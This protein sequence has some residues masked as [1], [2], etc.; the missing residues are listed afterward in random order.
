MRMR[1][2]IKKSLLAIA[3]SSIIA[4]PA[5][6][7]TNGYSM[8]GASTKE[9]GLAGAGVAYSQDA[10]ASAN[11]PAGMAFIGE[12]FDVG[13]AVFSPSPRSYT[14]TGNVTPAGFINAEDGV[15]VESDSDFFFIPHIGY[16]WQIDDTTTV[17]VAV[18]GNGGM[19]TDYPASATP[20]SPADPTGPGLGTFVDGKTGINLE[21][22]FFNV[23]IS[24]KLNAKHAIGASVLLVGQK[25][26][27][28]G[29]AGF[30][31]LSVDP[32]NVS[33]NHDD[34]A[35]GVGVKFGY[36]GE[37]SDGVRV[38]V[39]YQ[40]KI[41]MNEFDD[42]AG[43]F[44]EGGD[45]DI[46]ATYTIGMSFEVGSSGLIVADIQEIK[47]S[48]VASISNPL[49]PNLGAC[50]GGDVTSCLGGSNGPGFGWEDMT[51]YKIGYQLEAGDSTYRVGY[52]HA[53]QPI[54]ES[55]VFFNILAPAVV[56]DHITAGWTLRVGD[57]QEFNIAGLYVPSNSV[58]GDNPMDGGQTQ[59]EIEMT[60]WEVQA[61]WAW[62]Y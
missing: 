29:L 38:G 23:S 47:Y 12:R 60:Q 19:N 48:G 35:I 46:P 28:D 17:G 25:F 3:V 55:E 45:F 21:Q 59:I 24:N 53:D 8:H 2:T 50:M 13:L 40:S 10:L 18:Y 1:I 54:P 22:A 31:P 27:A 20:P 33:G 34:T 44:A 37:V 57:N 4:S 41:K 30:A 43:L 32:A 61:G 36:Q 49:M 14:V 16:N 52:S 5:V 51:V 11:N 9:K 62:K 6:N 58:K 26:R 15:E 7:A 39:S 42:Y 56:E